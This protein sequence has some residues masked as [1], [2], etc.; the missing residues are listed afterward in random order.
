MPLSTYYLIFYP[1]GTATAAT[2]SASRV[3]D[4]SQPPTS[5]ESPTAGNVID[6]GHDYEEESTADS[7]AQSSK[8]PARKRKRAESEF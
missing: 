4:V 6:L 2:S 1:G 3:P 8:D 5:S 7:A